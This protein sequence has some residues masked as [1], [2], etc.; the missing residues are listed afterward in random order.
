MEDNYFL[1]SSMLYESVLLSSSQDSV[2]CP[3][4]LPSLNLLG[5]WRSTKGRVMDEGQA[6]GGKDRGVG[7]ERQGGEAPAKGAFSF[8]Q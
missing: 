1:S 4:L 5:L 3:L 8:E 7:S 2:P 6:V